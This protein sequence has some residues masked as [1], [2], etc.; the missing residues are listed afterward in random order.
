MWALTSKI[1]FSNPNLKS[2]LVAFDSEGREK[3]KGMKPFYK[4]NTELF[5][6]IKSRS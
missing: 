4:K 3:M 5:P 6:G 2:V 1:I